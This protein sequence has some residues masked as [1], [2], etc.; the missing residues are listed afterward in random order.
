MSETYFR[1]TRPRTGYL[2]VAAETDPRSLSAASQRVRLNSSLVIASPNQLARR[3]SPPGTAGGLPVPY[4][5]ML[6]RFRRNTIRHNH[7]SIAPT[8]TLTSAA[9]PS[10]TQG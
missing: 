2:Y 4:H 1:N 7:Q 9:I 5:G 10:A 3:S 6:A 8:A